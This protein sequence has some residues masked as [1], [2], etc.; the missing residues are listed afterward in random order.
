MLKYHVIL[1]TIYILIHYIN[2][3][4]E[5]DWLCIYCKNY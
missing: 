1:L 3:T 2:Y 5:S 4:F